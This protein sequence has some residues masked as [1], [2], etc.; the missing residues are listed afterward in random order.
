MFY[1]DKKN[2]SE[3]NEGNAKGVEWYGA[4]SKQ[5][6]MEVIQEFLD[7]Y[8]ICGSDISHEERKEKYC[9][10]YPK[11]KTYFDKLDNDFLSASLNSGKGW[12]EVTEEYRKICVPKIENGLVNPYITKSLELTNNKT[13]GM[14]LHYCDKLKD[15][16][17]VVEAIKNNVIPLDIIRQIIGVQRFKIEWGIMRQ[18]PL[19]IADFY[20]KYLKDL[21]KFTFAE[22]LTMQQY[23]DKG[24]IQKIYK[25][26]QNTLSDLYN[27]SEDNN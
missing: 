20:N 25:N 27:E 19:F 9:A 1:Y 21:H 6:V 22:F 23:G 12:G 17:A 11:A 3:N 8:E 18:N 26:F 5:E 13:V 10:L 4:Y 14:V 7:V 24:D 16:S 15:S 2:Y